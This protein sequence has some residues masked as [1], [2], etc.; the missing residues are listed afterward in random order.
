VFGGALMPSAEGFELI[1]SVEETTVAYGED[2]VV[3]VEL[4]NNSGKD[5]EI[6]FDYL[7]WPSI[8][9]WDIFTEQ[10]IVGP[11]WLQYSSSMSFEAGSVLRN[12]ETWGFESG[13]RFLGASLTPG[14]HELKFEALF[15]LKS[16]H[17]DTCHESLQEITVFSNTIELEV[18]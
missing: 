14:T 4:K 1:I 13:P 11:P 3:N 10:N 15:A 5:C 16:R 7:F 18:R 9:N 17:V 8:L 2:F 6:F 12:I